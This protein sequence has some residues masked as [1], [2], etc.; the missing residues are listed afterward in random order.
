MARI[1][2]W[3]ILSMSL[4]YACKEKSSEG[5][6]SLYRYGIPV[7]IDIPKDAAIN[8]SADG[9][10]SGLTI[11]DEEGFNMQVMQTNTSFTDAK[12]AKFYHREQVVNNPD[13]TKIIEDY[14]EGFLFELRDGEDRLYDFRFVKIMGTHEI[15]FQAGP[16][17]KC[18]EAQVRN[19]ILSVLKST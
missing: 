4:L 12:M 17:C 11:V 15:I 16:T 10:V 18:S 1:V 6:T 13:F 8:K 9:N 7:H 5:K 3:C 14:D 19:M 2:L